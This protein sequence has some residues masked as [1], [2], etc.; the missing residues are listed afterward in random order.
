LRHLKQLVFATSLLLAATFAARA[1]SLDDLNIQL[2]GYATQGFLYS[3]HNNWDSTNSSDG[4]PAWTEAVVDLSAQPTSRL[5]ITMQSRY[6]LLG[7]YGN[8]ISL[9]FAAADFKVNDRFG[10]RFGKVKTPNGIFNET[11]DIDPS[12]IWSL[13]PESNYPIASRD[14][15]LSHYGAVVYGTVAPIPAIGKFEYRAYGGDRIMASDDGFFVPINANGVYFPNGLAGPTFG[16]ALNWKTPLPGL[17]LGAAIDHD[18]L[19]GA[20][21]IPAAGLSGVNAGPPFTIPFFYGRFERGRFSFTAEYSR[22][23]IDFVSYF[24]GLPPNHSI[25][26]KR[27]WYPMTTYRINSKLTAGAY[28][29]YFLDRKAALGPNRYQK[30]WVVSGRYDFNQFLY[31]KAEQH[32]MT[33]LALDDFLGEDNTNPALKTRLTILKLGVSF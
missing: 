7:N 32:F 16:G 33:G 25:F 26:D 10:V 22:V 27:E 24:P 4:S 5:H 28:Y 13:L 1:Q 11:Q 17:L 20:V 9:D 19:S 15:I 18:H 31:A 29:S 30:D 3:N 14:S 2:H 21:T 23:A 6:F 12:Y 8:A